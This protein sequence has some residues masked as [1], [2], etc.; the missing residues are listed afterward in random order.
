MVD[1]KVSNVNVEHVVKQ[2]KKKDL[3]NSMIYGSINRVVEMHPINKYEID[4]KQLGVILKEFN[5]KDIDV[6]KRLKNAKEAISI[7]MGKFEELE[8][9]MKEYG[10]I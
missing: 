10:I 5:D 4:G 2:K 6:D 1:K 8:R 9:K 3:P 7:L